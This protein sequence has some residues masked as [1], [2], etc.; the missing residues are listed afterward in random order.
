M[1]L[2]ASAS[3]ISHGG[4]TLER[5]ALVKVQAACNFVNAEV[6]RLR[7]QTIAI[8]AIAPVAAMLVWFVTGFGDSRV[9]LLIATGVVMI[10]F[11]RA[12]T[13]ASNYKKMAVKR[14][15]SGFGSGLSYSSKSS[16]T[17]DQFVA[18]D[19]FNDHCGTLKGRHEISGQMQGVRYSA[20]EVKAVDIDGR[21]VVFDGLIIKLDFP[22]LF[23]GNTL[24]VPAHAGPAPVTQSQRT[25]NGKKRDFVIVKHPAFE[26]LFDVYSTDYYEARKLV[27]PKFMDFVTETR[28]GLDGEMRLCFT[29]KSLVIALAGQ[30]LGFDVSLFAPPLTP[31]GAIGKLVQLIGLAERLGE[32]Y[33]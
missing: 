18:M 7:H 30:G 3:R 2:V 25:L 32:L 21:S 10:A 9:V 28:R 6:L 20:H 29:Q 33:S 16:L 8:W 17:R 31:Q 14:I 5:Q 12:R 19:L 1:A 22:T 15:V 27:T 11:V 4:T 24:I 13:E 23:P 26:R